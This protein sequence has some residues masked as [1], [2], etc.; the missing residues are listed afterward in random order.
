MHRVVTRLIIG[1]VL[2]AAFAPVGLGLLATSAAGAERGPRVVLDG[3]TATAERADDGGSTAS[4]E[5]I[6]TGRA[7]VDLDQDA[8]EA[9]ACGVELGTTQLLGLR[10]TTVDLTLDEDCFDD[11]SEVEVDLDGAGVLPPATISA[12]AEEESV[13]TPL[14]WAAAV[15]LVVAVGVWSFACE[16]RATV[17]GAQ[18]APSDDM[19][20]DRERRYV[21]V[22]D[23][24]TSRLAGLRGQVPG[25]KDCPAP[26]RFG[27]T[28]AVSGLEAGWSF[29]D[30]WVSN[31]TVAST[32]F[33]A[34]ATSVDAFT[35]LLGEE[36]KAALRVMTV[37]GLVSA[38]LIALANT[39]V[40][41][42][43]TST[44]KVS[45]AGLVAS[46]CLVVF[47]ATFQV[48]S[49]GLGAMSLVSGWA[50]AAAFLLMLAVGTALVAYAHRTLREMLEKGP[51][52]NLP[53]VPADA[54]DAWKA[55]TD[56]EKQLVGQRV[57]ATFAEWLQDDPVAVDAYPLPD[58]W[59]TTSPGDHG[60]P[61]GQASLL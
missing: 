25:W 58:G 50:D 24:V 9:G 40:K 39:L 32:G 51:A 33:I 42:L 3:T 45:V 7:R 28:A 26:A 1:G 2:G 20:D 44:T 30:S 16:T 46:T 59:P 43:G 52:D 12:P 36:P 38:A 60:F 5:L 34:L 6:N 47:A 54:L 11:A 19:I 4:V 21:A 17:D 61:S 55:G 56:W 13:W 29:K 22:R 27:W 23:L 18:A 37:A 41:L 57:R 53:V 8:V 49:V 48:V 15:G 31:L 35:A 14:A 10:T